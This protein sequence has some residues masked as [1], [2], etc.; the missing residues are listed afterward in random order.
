MPGFCPKLLDFREYQP[1]TSKLLYDRPGW[2]VVVV[3]LRSSD[4]GHMGS[5]G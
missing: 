1:D 4:L 5:E 2:F 3:P